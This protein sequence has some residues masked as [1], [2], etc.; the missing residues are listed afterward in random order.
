MKVISTILLALFIAGCAG[1]DTTNQQLLHEAVIQTPGLSADKIHEKTKLWVARNFRSAKSVIGYDD[2]K[3]HL[4]T[5]NGSINV[6]IYMAT[7]S[8]MGFKFTI[9]S[10]DNRFKITYS[11]YYWLNN[12]HE[13]YLSSVYSKSNYDKKF[14]E[15]NTQLKAYLLTKENNSNW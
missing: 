12:S 14:T 3:N 5:G 11:D 7:D 9:E 13:S 10:K 15:L 2:P 1:L 6:P 8:P 4:L